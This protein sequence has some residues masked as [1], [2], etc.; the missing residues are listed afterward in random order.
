MHVSS[1]RAALVIDDAESPIADHL[2]IAIERITPTEYD[3]A[4]CAMITGFI[5]LPAEQ[6][7][8]LLF[9]MSD[10]AHPD[11]GQDERMIAGDVLQS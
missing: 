9:A 1:L 10:G 7:G 4:G 2:F 11:L 8:L 3:N 5:E 6:V